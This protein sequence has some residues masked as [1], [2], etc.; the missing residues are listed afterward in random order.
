[1]FEK[2]IPTV[3]AQAAS[4]QVA[5]DEEGVFSLLEKA[6][7][8]L[9]TNIPRWIGAVVIVFLTFILAK[10]AKNFIESK[11]AEK[12]IEEEHKEISILGGRT[13]YFG[14]LI[15]GC[16]AGLK[17]AGI[18]LTTIIAAAAF[19]IG[20]ALRDLIMNFLAGVI[21]LLS[22]PFTIGDVISIKDTKGKV[23]EI[24]TRATILRAFNGTRIIV[25]NSELFSNQVINITGNGTRRV[26]IE[27]KLMFHNN[28]FVAI[29]A[30]ENSLKNTDGILPNPQPSINISAL[31]QGFINL[32][33]WFWVDVH[34]KWL[35]TKTKVIYNI[36]SDLDKYGIRIAVPIYAENTQEDIFEIQKLQEEKFKSEIAA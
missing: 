6:I 24:Q 35:A 22:K 14:V 17:I 18:D 30:I 10:M 5:K 1:M 32:K 28:L 26:E 19:G 27:V 25:P 34:S 8:F 7:E 23:M 29:G 20:F 3:F 4:N 36:K 13:V 11:M 33:V 16:T 15:L 21:I 12:G 31:D 2:L 9:I